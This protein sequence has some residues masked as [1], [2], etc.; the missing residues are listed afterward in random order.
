VRAG[1]ATGAG[2]FVLVD[3]GAAIT[4]VRAY[5]V[6]SHLRG[7]IGHTAFGLA[8]GAMLRIVSRQ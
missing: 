5:P 2:A 1:V 3:E 8:A 4:K 7:V 6:E